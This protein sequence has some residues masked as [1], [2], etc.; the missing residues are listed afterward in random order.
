MFYA[1]NNRIP[2][3]YILLDTPNT[4]PYIRLGNWARSAP[5]KTVR[6]HEIGCV[7]DFWHAI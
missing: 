4:S 7:A 3:F 2:K 1:S 5:R 6:M